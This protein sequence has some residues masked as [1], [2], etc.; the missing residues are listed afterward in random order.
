MY[1][2][3]KH[4]DSNTLICV[5]GCCGSRTPLVLEVV[6]NQQALVAVSSGVCPCTVLQVCS[7]PSHNYL[8]DLSY[9]D[10]P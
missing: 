3:N 6:V 8:F 5:S 4:L 1:L 10:L 2:N 9:Q 7:L